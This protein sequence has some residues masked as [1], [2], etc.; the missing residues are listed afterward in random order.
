MGA[1]SSGEQVQVVVMLLILP[2]KSGIE[3]CRNP[4]CGYVPMGVVQRDAAGGGT[5]RITETLKCNRPCA[6]GS[7]A[8]YTLP[9]ILPTFCSRVIAGRAY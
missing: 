5:D 7:A 6:C 4:D 1:V 8:A 9:M 3:A 2:Y